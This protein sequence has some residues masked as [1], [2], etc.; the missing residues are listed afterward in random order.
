MDLFD[1]IKDDILDYAHE[2]WASDRTVGREEVDEVRQAQD[3]AIENIKRI[4]EPYR[5]D[6][7]RYRKLKVVH[8]NER[9]MRWVELA[10][11]ANLDAAVDALPNPAPGD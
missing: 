9:W 6:A 5:I 11:Q 10:E 7:Q 8:A 4:L 3:T 1:L 2:E